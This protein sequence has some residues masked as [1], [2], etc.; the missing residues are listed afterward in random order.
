MERY[1]GGVPNSTSA[2]VWGRIADE[3]TRD[4]SLGATLRG[5][6]SELRSVAREHAM[7]AVLEAQR[8]GFNLAYLLA[9]VLVVSVLGVTAWLAL[10]TAGVMW[11]VQ[12]EAPW[13]GVLLL[14]ALLNLAGAAFIAFWLKRQVSEMPFAATLRQ[15]SAHRE[16]I[17]TS[18][19]HAQATRP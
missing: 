13:P 11:M 8:A 10:I 7:L 16:E 5:V 19:S 18:G 17:S 6:W 12:R 3:P 1:G 4:G 14:A 9:G 2:R 15:F